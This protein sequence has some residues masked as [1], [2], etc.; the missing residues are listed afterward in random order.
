[1]E[2]LGLLRRRRWWNQ[3]CNNATAFGDRHS[4]HLATA[5]AIE[6]LK[7][8]GLELRRSDCVRVGGHRAARMVISSHHIG[9]GWLARKRKGCRGH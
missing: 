9:L 1:M 2:L 8:M 6:Q 4:V 7:A 3:Y 5:H